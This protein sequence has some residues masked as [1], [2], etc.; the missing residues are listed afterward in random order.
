MRR[1][2]KLQMKYIQRFG[3]LQTNKGPTVQVSKKNRFPR[4]PEKIQVQ[5]VT[6]P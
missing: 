3:S 4:F 5:P 1:K 6:R 2:V